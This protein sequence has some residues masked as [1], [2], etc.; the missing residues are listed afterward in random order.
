MAQP[1]REKKGESSRSWGEKGG[2]SPVSSWG[3][4]EKWGERTAKEK[5]KKKTV[6]PVSSRGKKKH[7]RLASKSLR[8]GKGR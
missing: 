1:T 2:L 6:Q 3:K 4:K 7:A 5:K 8:K